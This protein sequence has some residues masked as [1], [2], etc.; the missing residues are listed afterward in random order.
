MKILIASKIYSA[1]IEKLKENHEVVCAFGADKETLKSAI[2]GCDVLIFRSG[3]DIS[4][5]VMAA[6]PSLKLLIRAGSGVD[7]LDMNYVNQRGLR[8]IR[9][10]GPGAKA[11]AELTFALMLALARNLTEADRLTK[12]GHWAKHELT[13]Y[14]LT[15]KV[16]GILGAGNIGLLVAHM[17]VAWGMKVLACVEHPSPERKKEFEAAV[18]ELTTCEQIIAESDFISVHVPLKDATRNFIDAE[19][20]AHVK[21]NA[22]LAN[23]ARGGVVNE[24]ALY[25]ALVEGR[26]G[27]AALD[28]HQA[29]GE[30][31]ISPLAGLKNV[32]LT[33]HIGA[34]TFD[35]QKEIGEIII[36]SVETFM[37]EQFALSS[38]QIDSAN[39]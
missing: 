3:V 27:G 38:V 20:L 31:K 6:A 8:L 26:L 19:D 12:Q 23:M 1:S 17:G 36:Q 21:P 13:G 33:P 9:I 15:G 37:S 39:V 5:E 18:I 25:N 2:Q 34:S 7:N 35:S 16:L 30:G 28:V 29:E 22:F 14:L 4:A 24:A 10:P 32:I 11:V